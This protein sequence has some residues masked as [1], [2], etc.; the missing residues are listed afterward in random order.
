MTVHLSV[1]RLRES[2]RSNIAFAETQ[3]DAG[4][5]VLRGVLL[6]RAGPGNLA[7]R[8]WYTKESIED[9]ARTG[10]F[11]GAQSY[12]D[13]PSSWEEQVQPGRS[14]EKLAGYYAEVTSR[15]FNDPEI[16]P[17]TGL[18]ADFYPEVGKPAVLS[19]LRTC[20]EYASR[21]PRMAY[22]GLS[23][24]A[25]G[26]SVPDTIDGEEWNRVDRIYEVSSVDIVTRA[27]AGGTLVPLKESYF[28]MKTQKNGRAK[29]GDNV[30]LTLD[31]DAVK[32][33]FKKT[34]EGAVGKFKESIK[35]LTVKDGK[36]ELTKE[37]EDALLKS[38]TLAEAVDKV[39]DEATSVVED[40]E[41]EAAAASTDD[42]EDDDVDALPDDAAKLKAK[43]KKERAARRA[44][45]GKVELAESRAS[46]AETRATEVSLVRMA[47]NVLSSLEIPDDFR[48]RII[49][50][51]KQMGYT[52]E[53]EMREHAQAFD[54]AFIRRTDSA[55]VVGTNPGGGGAAVGNFNFEEVD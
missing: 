34:L 7:D 41:A 28:G 16:G 50:E 33:G 11:E 55:G 29:T 9:A 49:L 31:A 6:L 43:I 13:H 18:F 46:Q 30:K 54:K 8:H 2:T 32:E 4:L 36:V 15:P 1:V 10:V 14:V 47:E 3:T 39:V 45:E 23:I 52:R 27:G 24:Y 37:Q 5:A 19:I 17:T 42:P 48:P 51:I 12:L 40:D 25:S 20:V 35:A 22:A 26:D 38:L 21:Y 44:A 53:R